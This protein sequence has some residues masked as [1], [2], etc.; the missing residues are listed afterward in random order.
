[1]TMSKLFAKTYGFDDGHKQKEP[2][3]VWFTHSIDGLVLF[4]VFYT[5]A[6]RWGKC[7]G[8]NLPSLS[9]SHHIGYLDIM[10]QVDTLFS[11]TDVRKHRKDIRQVVLS[12]NGSVFDQE[13]FSTTALMYFMAVV[14]RELPNLAVL[15]IETQPDYVDMEELEILARAIHEGTTPT[16]L[17]VA[18]GFEAYDDRIRNKVFLK[19]LSLREVENLAEKLAKHGFRLKCY[20][21]QKPVPD[22]TDEEAVRDIQDGIDYLHKLATRFGIAVT[23]HLNPTYAARGT[24]L[25]T[26][27]KNGIYAPPRLADVAR[28][29]RYAQGKRVAVHFGLNDEGLATEGGSFIRPGEEEFLKMLERFNETQDFSLIEEKG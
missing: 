26:A 7:A 17:E 8:C 21:M 28:A 24:I 15:T 19:G 4:V 23:M 14:N 12:N 3:Q 18:I 10:K 5:Q 1:M 20:F 16:T 27:L 13:I 2:A 22:M 11:R 25:E 6:C 29:A 9:S